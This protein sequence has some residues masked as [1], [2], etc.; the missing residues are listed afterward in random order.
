MW[1]T[2]FSTSLSPLFCFVLPRLTIW[3]LYKSQRQDEACRQRC[4]MMNSL[5]DLQHLPA[6]Y[7]GFLNFF[8]EVRKSIWIVT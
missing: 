3:P 7:S 2:R 6:A 8:E 5:F 1:A 4:L